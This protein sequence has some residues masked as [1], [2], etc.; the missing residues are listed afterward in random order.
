MKSQAKQHLGSEFRS[1]AWSLPERT[2]LRLFS[3]LLGKVIKQGPAPA[4]NIS[5]KCDVECCKVV[6]SHWVQLHCFPRDEELEVEN[7]EFMID[8]HHDP[9]KITYMQQKIILHTYEQKSI[10]LTSGSSYVIKENVDPL[11]DKILEEKPFESDEDIEK[12]ARDIF[13]LKVDHPIR[14]FRRGKWGFG[15]D[16]QNLLKLFCCIKWGS[17]CILNALTCAII[18]TFFICDLCLRIT[19]KNRLFCW[20][21]RFPVDVHI[22]RLMVYHFSNKCLRN[23]FTGTYLDSLGSR[24]LNWRTRHPSG[25]WKVRKGVRVW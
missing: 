11:T 14:F 19:L 16:G 22:F 1:W 4:G 23:R 3:C 15:S 6:S 18:L 17:I 9:T 21:L 25:A 24:F 12:A 13:H 7:F 20:Y 8:F 5:G 2:K 10:R